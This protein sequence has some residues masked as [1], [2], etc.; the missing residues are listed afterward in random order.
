MMLDWAT[1]RV[2]V[3][4]GPTDMRK[5][6]NGLSILVTEDLAMDPFSGSLFLFCNKHK[7]ILKAIY[8][9]KNGFCQWMKRLEK[10]T[11][12]WPMK[13]SEATEISREQFEFLL[14]GIDFW[15]AYQKLDYRSIS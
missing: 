1:V 13:A 10:D 11:F 7:R 5:P 12:P 15:N 8:G 2:F 6:I 4:P 9:D 14:A 3:K